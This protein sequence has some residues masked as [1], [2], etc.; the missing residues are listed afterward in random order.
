MRNLGKIALFRRNTV[1]AVGSIETCYINRA[2]SQS[3]CHQCQYRERPIFPTFRLTT[4]CT[5]KMAHATSVVCGMRVDQLTR[6]IRDSET[7]IDFV[8]GPP[9]SRR[10][11]VKE[12]LDWP[13]DCSSLK[14]E[15]TVGPRLSGYQLS[16]YLCYPATILQYI[17]CIFN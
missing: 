3:M 10:E 2:V 11:R 8:H 15:N 6:S 1:F 5:S 13:F 4:T 7:S 9:G 14:Y 17:L 16:R 12:I